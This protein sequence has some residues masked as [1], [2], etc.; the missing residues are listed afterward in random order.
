MIEI[1]IKNNAMRIIVTETRKIIDTTPLPMV[2]VELDCASISYVPL[3]L[4]SLSVL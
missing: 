3:V 4:C 1:S 2:V